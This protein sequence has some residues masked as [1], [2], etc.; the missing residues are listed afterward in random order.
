MKQANI[1]N[2]IILMLLL[3][4]MVPQVQAAKAAKEC[5]CVAY[6]KAKIGTSAAVGNAKDMGSWLKRNGWRESSTPSVGAIAVL[7]PSFP[8]SDP[9]D[10][11]VG[12]VASVRSQGNK[13]AIDIRGANQW[14]G[15]SKYTDAGCSNVR[16]TGWSAF[17]KNK[18]GIKFYSK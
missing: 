11:H 9:S 5:S 7:Q 6:V 1:M 14:V 13:W 4:I 2:T 8:G 15:G 16:V 17:D 18:S 10:G 3:S 12:F